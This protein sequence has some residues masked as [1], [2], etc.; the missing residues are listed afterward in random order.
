MGAS[1]AALI[2]VGLAY[3]IGGGGDRTLTRFDHAP[4]PAYAPSQA[5]PG[6][7]VRAYEQLKQV[8]ADRGAAGVADFAHGCGQSLASNPRALD[9]C[10]A[11]DVYAASLMG[12][13]EI[14][15]AWRSNAAE[16]QLA[17]AR[18]AL[19]PTE[20]P[21][22]RVA[23]VRTLARQTSLQDPDLAMRPQK[24]KAAPHR[25]K[26]RYAKPR[27]A[28]AVAAATEAS[29]PQVERAAAQPADQPAA[30]PAVSPSATTVAE[31]KPRARPAAVKRASV[32]R[33]RTPATDACRR[34]STAGERTVCA[35]PALR[36]A[37]A[38]LQAAYRRAVAAGADPKGLARDQARFRR[39][40]NAA[41]PDRVAV[42]RLYY[43]RT[44]T[45]EG[46][47]ESP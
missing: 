27:H 44:R 40:V 7:V 32:K 5:D 42:E 35:S 17:L 33:A 36:Q 45:L 15:R 3:W 39:A 21:V 34:K 43:Q 13:D 1:T 46:L 28:K 10:L 25:A 30:Q 11:F 23:R 18:V 20:D 26:P 29:A 9:F 41:A 47:S 2:S 4:P 37:D 38:Q 14:A 6:Q 24:A 12:D 31:A 22:A 8:Y 16:R 19:P